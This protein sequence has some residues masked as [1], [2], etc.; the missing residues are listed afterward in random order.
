MREI[1]TLRARRR[2][3]ET[4]LRITLHGHEGENPGYSQGCSCGPPRQPST[5]PGGRNAVQDSLVRYSQRKTTEP[6]GSRQ[7]CN[8]VPIR[9]VEVVHADAARLATGS[10]PVPTL[11]AL[12]VTC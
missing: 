2:G 5:L 4:E 1:R 11:V 8:R 10:V 9:Q 3:L 6:P 7:P 12:R